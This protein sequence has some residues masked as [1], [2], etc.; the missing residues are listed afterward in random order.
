MTSLIKT[1]ANAG[2]GPDSRMSQNKERRFRNRRNPN[3]ID[4]LE[5]TKLPDKACRWPNR[6]EPEARGY[7]SEPGRRRGPE[8][9]E[10]HSPYFIPF[11][12]FKT[13]G[14]PWEGRRVTSGA[15]R[16]E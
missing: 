9:A 13:T 4:V 2:M 5:K 8:R 6:P 15:Y 10:R 3:F 1:P 14:N 12:G 16:K 7:V 11:C